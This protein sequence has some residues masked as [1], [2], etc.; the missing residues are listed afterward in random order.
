[1]RSV[2]LAL[3][4]LGI[5]GCGQRTYQDVREAAADGE[6]MVKTYSD[7]SKA[8]ALEV[9][10]KVLREAGADAFRGGEEVGYLIAEFKANA[11]TAGSFCGVY[12]KEVG[13][14]LEVRVICLRKS[15]MNMATGITENGFFNRFARGLDPISMEITK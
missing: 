6:G 13:K 2:I 15:S 11:V 4:V 8:K 14:D 1:M 9:A 12:P 3:S 5:L 7:L 10:K